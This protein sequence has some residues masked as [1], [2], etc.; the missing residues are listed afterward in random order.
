MGVIRIRQNVLAESSVGMIATAG[1][2]VGR[3]NSWLSGVDATYQTSHF[4]GSDNFLLGVWTLAMNREDI[5]GTRWAGGLKIDYPND[6]WDIATT[7]KRIDNG[8]DP[9]L[10]FVPRAG[11]QIATLG[12]DYSPRPQKPVGPLRDRQ[13]LYEFETQLV[14]NLQNRWESYEV[15]MAPV[16]W[17][18]E[19]GDRFEMNVVRAGERLPED[20]EIASG[21]TIPAGKYQWTRYR[22]EAG[23]ASKRRFGG[24]ATWWFGGFYSGHLDELELTAAWKPSSLFV[25]EL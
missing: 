17:R 14:T 7:F 24:Q 16:N 10:G 25:K 23:T 18:L 21:V 6:L 9:S 2:P 8:F 13:M 3:A 12:I 5:D 19:S 4:R 11:V 22:L 1:D 15:F 20:F